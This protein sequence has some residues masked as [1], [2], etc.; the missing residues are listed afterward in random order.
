MSEKLSAVLASIKPG[1]D[2]ASTSPAFPS[3]LQ[4]Y[5]DMI[6]AIVPSSTQG[7]IIRTLHLLDGQVN[8]KTAADMLASA[9][10]L[11]CSSAASEPIGLWGTICHR[12][13]T[14][15]EDKLAR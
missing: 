8:T 3:F 6:R 5:E 2:Q 7:L 15:P 1:L 9:V 11:Q 13:E 14:W 12:G 4:E 10:S